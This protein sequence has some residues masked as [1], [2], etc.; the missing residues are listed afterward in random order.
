MRAGKSGK[1]FGSG[2]KGRGFESRHFDHANH[3][4]SMATGFCFYQNTT[5]VFKDEN[6]YWH[7]IRSRL[8]ITSSNQFQFEVMDGDGHTTESV[9]IPGTDK[10]VFVTRGMNTSLIAIR[11]LDKPVVVKTE[12]SKRA[13]RD[14][15]E[16][17]YELIEMDGFTLEECMSFFRTEE[18][19]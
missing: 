14:I 11:T 16:Y 6:K 8:S 9:D 2:P 18:S 15:T 3:V 5:T 19:N 10:A 13:L 17:K 7:S 4:V 1:I 12:P